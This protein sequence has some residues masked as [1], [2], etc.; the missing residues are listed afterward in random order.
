VIQIDRVGRGRR[1]VG[2]RQAAQQ[3]GERPADGEARQ[4]F[5]A[6]VRLGQLRVPPRRVAGQAI[7]HRVGA[8]E[9]RLRVG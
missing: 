2:R 3:L 9:P 5:A 4:Q 1:F 6:P 7:E 8:V